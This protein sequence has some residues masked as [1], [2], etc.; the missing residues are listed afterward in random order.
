MS[1]C[2]GRINEGP[3]HW[4]WRHDCDIAACRRHV[5]HPMN[6]GSV[7]EPTC[8][9]VEGNPDDL[10]D[11]TQ[12]IHCEGCPD[13][14]DVCS[15]Q[16]N[17]AETSD[18]HGG[19]RADRL[20]PE[21]REDVDDCQALVDGEEDVNRGGVRALLAIIHRFAPRPHGGERT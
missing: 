3:D 6:E 12:R 19:E 5:D 15:P 1:D 4:C 13:V 11:R 16:R 2:E 10:M 8:K 18:V 7:H 21:E 9:G 17:S 20:T 14:H